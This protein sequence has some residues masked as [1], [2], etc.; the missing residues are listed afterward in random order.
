MDAMQFF[1]FVGITVTGFVML[2]VILE[3][4]DTERFGA[5]GERRD[6][7]EPAVRSV[8]TLPAFFVGRAESPPP[9][10]AEFNDALIAFLEE[11]VRTERAIV[12]T[13][14]HLPSL[15]SLYRQAPPF[16]T[17]H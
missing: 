17:M 6:E 1:G 10:R 8:A 14:V 12:N 11:H 7:V 3:L 15:D 13:F 9:A 2:A 5:R 16:P 4:L